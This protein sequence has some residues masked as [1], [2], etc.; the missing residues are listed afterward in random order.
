MTYNPEIHHRYSIRL[1]GY[2]YSQAGR[3]FITICTQ[4]REC[5]FGEI[6]GAEMNVNEYGKIVETEWLNLKI[7]YPNIELY[8]F[9]VMPN[10][11]HGILQIVTVGAGFARPDTNT[12][13]DRAGNPCPNNNPCP[14]TNP[15]AY[16]AG[17][18]RPYGPTLGNIVAYF[19]YKTTK[20]IDLPVKLWQRNYYE[21]IIRNEQSY[22]NISCYIIRNPE[23]WQDDKFHHE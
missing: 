14:N 9:V 18:P 20:Q 1:K 21:H 23:K 19:K 15:D 12:D 16:R 7:K 3:Y 22:Q 6:V 10:H 11:F 8:E 5:L 4:N 17:E 2:D 13:T